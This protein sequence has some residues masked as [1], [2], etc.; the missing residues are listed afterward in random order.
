M[1]FDKGSEIHAENV[2]AG[3]NQNKL[4]VGI[5]H[6]I[7]ILVNGLGRSAK[8]FGFP[9]AHKRRHQ[10]DSAVG[11]I[12]VIR[13]T[14][15]NMIDERSGEILDDD[16]DII[17]AGKA[18]VGERKVDDAKMPTERKSGFGAVMSQDGIP[19]GNAPGQYQSSHIS[20]FVKS[21]KRI[22]VRA[23]AWILRFPITPS[24]AV[25]FYSG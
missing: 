22:S 15:A 24:I 8:P 6:E 14:H 16:S 12:E 25:S 17:D 10:L 21:I 18:K 7:E 20:H 9:H 13:A 5:P 11:G 19:M 4:G 2:I 23:K 1:E 3:K